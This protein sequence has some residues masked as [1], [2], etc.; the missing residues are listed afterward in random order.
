MIITAKPHTSQPNETAIF[1]S[2][3]VN[4]NQALPNPTLSIRNRSQHPTVRVFRPRTLRKGSSAPQ[5]FG[6]HAATWTLQLGTVESLPPFLLGFPTKTLGP[7]MM[8]AC[9]IVQTSSQLHKPHGAVRVFRCEGAPQGSYV[10]LSWRSILSQVTISHVKWRRRL[11]LHSQTPGP[12]GK[13]L[14]ASLLV[15]GPMIREA[16]MYKCCCL[17]IKLEWLE[18]EKASW[19][20]L[21]TILYK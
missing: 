11:Q 15:V 16:H 18:P 12:W 4:L 21:V 19:I 17:L 6:K 13:R 1:Q 8:V 3:T 2:L 5:F 9:C 7:Q 10:S 20:H 14:S